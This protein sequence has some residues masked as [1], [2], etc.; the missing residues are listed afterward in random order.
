MLIDEKQWEKALRILRTKDR[1]DVAYKNYAYMLAHVS[2]FMSLYGK[3]MIDYQIEDQKVR[4]YKIAKSIFALQRNLKDDNNVRFD[5]LLTQKISVGEA[6]T[7][8]VYLEEGDNAKPFNEVVAVI[9]TDEEEKILT[10]LALEI[11][12]L[13]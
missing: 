9:L 8:I 5:K 12:E 7:E 3:H 1:E 2:L 4:L 6:I 11:Y 10:Q 13:M